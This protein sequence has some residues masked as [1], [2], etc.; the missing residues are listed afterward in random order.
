MPKAAKGSSKKA[1]GDKK[2]KKA[3]K[4]PKEPK[5]PAAAA[6]P[7]SSPH[8]DAGRLY[9][10]YADRGA[11]GAAGTISRDSF[12]RMVSELDI[13][14]PAGGA[15]REL[16]TPRT[17]FEAGRV[18]ERYDDAAA[19]GVDKAQ[20]EALLYQNGW[21]GP[22]SAADPS[23]GGFSAG[24]LFER[25]DTNKTGRLELDEVR[26]LV[27]DMRAGKVP[28][29]SGGPGR[30]SGP[31]LGPWAGTGSGA[32]A[33]AG[34]APPGL[35]SSFGSGNLIY[36]SAY[37]APDRSGNPSGS[38]AH[39][40]GIGASPSSAL[41]D[42]AAVSGLMDA[43]HS[44]IS[45]LSAVNA[46]LMAK[47]EASVN[48]LVRIAAMREE[49]ASARRAVERETLADSEAVL[50]RLRSAEALKQSLLAHDAERL[51]SDVQA[52]D[53]FAARLADVAPASGDAGAES[54]AGAAVA[55]DYGRALSLM[56]VYPEL[57]ADADRLLARPLKTD[58][59][60]R[61]DDFEREVATRA[62]VVRRHRALLDLLSAKD[63]IIHIL[64][65]E[66][67]AAA[68]RL[69]SAQ[70]ASAAEVRKW[71]QLAE[72]LA[73]ELQGIRSEGEGVGTGTS[74]A[75]RV[76]D[77][78]ARALAD[79][80]GA[81]AAAPRRAGELHG[82]QGVRAIGGPAAEGARRPSDTSP[83]WQPGHA[84]PE[85]RPAAGKHASG[86]DFG[87]TTEPDDG[88]SVADMEP[89]HGSRDGAD[90]EAPGDGDEHA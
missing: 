31:S 21:S 86:Q 9:E 16:P 42:P 67:E 51:A 68:S 89:F 13:K 84:W 56:R 20:F 17:D 81:A 11:D 82:R 30:W 25:Y 83:R 69:G 37:G 61:S 52:M 43:Y 45:A 34:A 39:A 32:G 64:L 36:G 48:Q 6:P 59:E 78:Q 53:A 66:R 88:G 57:C 50:H 14:A 65:R 80:T 62:A 35:P 22:H 49:V 15:P 90:S 63:A 33:S 74:E 23:G 55:P 29:P 26:R 58:I 75:A 79:A 3:K 46:R 73:G 18:F 24:Q 44:R 2:A 41:V 5:A 54:G 85:Q 12:A 47:R 70:Q 10:R 7:S 28:V 1:S 4:E 77:L 27:A 19:G 87:R 40:G 60:V 71:V 38:T 8:F 72:Q 76:V